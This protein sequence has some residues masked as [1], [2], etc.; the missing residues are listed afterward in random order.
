M[1]NVIH[2]GTYMFSS[3]NR[4][5][6]NQHLYVFTVFKVI[7]VT[8]WPV[9]SVIRSTTWSKDGDWISTGLTF[10]L[11]FEADPLVTRPKIIDKL[12][13]RWSCITHHDFIICSFCC[14]VTRNSDQ[15]FRNLDVK[16]HFAFTVTTVYWLSL[17]LVVYIFGRTFTWK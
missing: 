7:L 11:S 6:R 15:K 12:L 16:C 4:V 2:L 13:Q 17:N 10:L 8:S 9:S 14:R 3:E 1:S 5:F